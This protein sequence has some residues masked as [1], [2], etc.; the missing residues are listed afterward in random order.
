MCGGWFCVGVGLV[1][2]YIGFV[3]LYICRLELGS[4]IRFK[5]RGE[6]L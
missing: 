5:F 3:D 4:Q 1:G 2:L 6:Q